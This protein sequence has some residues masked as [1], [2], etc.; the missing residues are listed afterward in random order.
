MEDIH[1]YVQ[2]NWILSPSVYLS[3]NIL[4]VYIVKDTQ[5]K[6]QVLKIHFFGCFDWLQ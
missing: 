3:G 2:V 1:Y 4:L 6:A 5:G